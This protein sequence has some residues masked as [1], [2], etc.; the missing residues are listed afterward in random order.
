M[1]LLSLM[2]TLGDISTILASPTGQPLPQLLLQATG[3]RGAAF[4]LFFLST[5]RGCCQVGITDVSPC[6]RS[7]LRFGMLYR[8]FSVYLGVS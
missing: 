2:F 8:Y 1:F 5:S 4:G 6:D 7:L 3:E